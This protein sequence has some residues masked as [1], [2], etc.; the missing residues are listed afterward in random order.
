[1][2]EAVWAL[3]HG[4]FRVFLV[5]ILLANIT[6][7]E[8]LCGDETV[9]IPRGSF[10]TTQRTLAGLANVGRQVVRDGLKKLE[11]L[12]AITTRPQTHVYTVIT[13][14][15][16]DTY[17]PPLTAGNPHS[18]PPRTHEEPIRE[19][20]RSKKEDPVPGQASSGGSLSVPEPQ[21]VGTVLTWATYIERF[22]FDARQILGQT[23]EAIATT[24]RTGSVAPSV[25]DALAQSFDRY[26]AAAVLRA[27]R[28]YLDRNCAAEG[29]GERYLQ[30][31]VRGEARRLQG[32]VGA[33]DRPSAV[34]VNQSI[35]PAAAVR[36][37]TEGRRAI[38]RAL[39][40][41]RREKAIQVP[42]GAAALTGRNG[43]HR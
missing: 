6:E 5:C 32:G 16:F 29:K 14:L 20:K 25:L 28:I 19:K 11:K 8:W 17:S 43:A 26:P 40:E 31:I 10:I 21:I 35:P 39:G 42:V 33:A 12:G 37:K 13:I 41:A 1:M 4:Q 24:R 38:D 22:P 30:G 7:R 15:N 18:N 36:P 27:C 3:P 2:N 9:V 34:T 23:A